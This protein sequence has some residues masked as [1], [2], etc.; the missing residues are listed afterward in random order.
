M[1]IRTEDGKRL[2]NMDRVVSIQAGK[3]VDQP[4]ADTWEI[5]VG[6]KTVATFSTP[7][8][9]VKAMDRLEKWIDRGGYVAKEDA[10]GDSVYLECRKVFSFRTLSE[11]DEFVTDRPT[12]SVGE[13]EGGK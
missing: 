3:P 13:E 10:D 11:D 2:V 12:G 7:E 5:W 9:A 8:L 1:W 4:T 6:G